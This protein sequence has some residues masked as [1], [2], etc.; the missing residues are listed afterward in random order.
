[1]ENKKVVS[2]PVVDFCVMGLHNDEV[3]SDSDERVQEIASQVCEAFKDIGFVYLKNHG[4]PEDEVNRVRQI[5]D[6]FFLLPV[7]EKQKYAR[8]VHGSNHGWTALERERTN[9]A[10][11]ADLKEAFNIEMNKKKWPTTT[12]PSMKPSFE[13]LFQKCAQL[14]FRILKTIGIGLK[15]QNPEFLVKAHEN[16]GN[17]ANP[18]AMR[19]LFY[20]PIPNDYVVKKDQVRCG[21]HSDY[22]SITLLFQDE[23][24]GLQVFCTGQLKS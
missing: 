7:E 17:S 16:I 11:P 18:T 19:V 6:E 8:A 1:M 22:G 3:A 23:L 20:P 2:I 10:R 12:I 24:G 9:P 15:M 21:E 13:E 5:A 14:S 4:I